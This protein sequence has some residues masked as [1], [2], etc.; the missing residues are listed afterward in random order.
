MKLQNT[1]ADICGNTLISISS[2]N[3]TSTSIKCSKIQLNSSEF[4]TWFDVCWFSFFL[5]LSNVIRFGIIQPFNRVLCSM[6]QL[7]MLWSRQYTFCNVKIVELY[8]FSSFWKSSINIQVELL[9]QSILCEKWWNVKPVFFLILISY[10]WNWIYDENSIRFYS[11]L[12]ASAYFYRILLAQNYA[13]KITWVRYTIQKITSKHAARVYCFYK[14]PYSMR[15]I[16]ESKCWEQKRTRNLKEIQKA[17]K[18]KWIPVYWLLS[19]YFICNEISIENNRSLKWMPSLNHSPILLSIVCSFIDLH[20]WIQS[21]VFRIISIDSL[22]E[23][24]FPK[25]I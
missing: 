3:S 5:L 22:T 25:S 1:P 8:K 9:T 18:W 14:A 15:I 6:P 4:W 16:I 19:L 7:S 23:M 24:M 10:Q 13:S 12:R 20:F 17:C 11:L 21:T 2:M